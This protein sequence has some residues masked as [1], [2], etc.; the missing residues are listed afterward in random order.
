MILWVAYNCDFAAAGLDFVA[1]GHA[2]RRIVGT[3]GVKVWADFA[4][5]R[6]HIW[7][8]KDDDRVDIR[9]GGE[10]FSAF[11]GGHEG[12]ALAL[13]S[14]HGIVAV[15]RHYEFAAQFASRVQVAH[16]ADVKKFEAAVGQGDAFATFAPGRNS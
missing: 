3:F 5:D 10:N 13:E 16:V 12:T 9:E 4:N 8:G 15:D 11:F 6:A 7:F 14:A 1:L 2:L